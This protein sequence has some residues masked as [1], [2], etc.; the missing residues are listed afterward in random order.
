LWAN[1][2]KN[3]NNVGR[4]KEEDESMDSDSSSSSGSSSSDS[5]SSDSDLI[6]SSELSDTTAGQSMA[7]EQSAT[8]KQSTTKSLGRLAVKPPSSVS[9]L[10]DKMSK[11]LA[12]RDPSSPITPVDEGKAHSNGLSSSFN[13]LLEEMRK[14]SD[15][16]EVELV[17]AKSLL[18]RS[19]IPASLLNSR[20]IRGPP[21]VTMDHLG[22]FLATTGDPDQQN[23]RATAR[24]E[25][26][27]ILDHNNQLRKIFLHDTLFSA[28]IASTLGR[29]VSNSTERN[30]AESDIGSDGSHLENNFHL[31]IFF[32]VHPPDVNCVGLLS[33]IVNEDVLTKLG[34]ADTRTVKKSESSGTSVKS[35]PSVIESSLSEQSASGTVKHE[36]EPMDE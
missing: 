36:D 30:S 19:D 14:K 23:T 3:D 2:S 16:I 5:D 8:V 29:P 13:K 7:S 6:S 1:D 15:E 25:Y 9:S 21:D 12:E 18:K 33:E 34:I 10:S 35:D 27:Y 32:D 4:V 28:F 26:F 17:P 11:W 22:E 31:M 24:P 20:Y